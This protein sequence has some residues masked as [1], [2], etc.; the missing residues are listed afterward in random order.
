MPRPPRGSSAPAANLVH[1]APSGRPSRP[2]CPYGPSGTSGSR[3]GRFRCTGPGTPPAAPD[4]R[5]HARHAALRQ[6][7]TCAAPASGTPISQNQRTAG[8][9]SRSWSTVWLAPV[10]RSS[11]G[12]SAVSTTSGT[13]DSSASITAA[14]KCAAAVPDVHTTAT[15]RPLALASPSAQ[16]AA[17]RSSMRTLSRRSPASAR[18][19]N[20]IASGALRDPGATT[21]SR[22][23]HRTSS[24]A[25][26]AASAV[27]GFTGSPEE[28]RGGQRPLAPRLRVTFPG[29]EPLNINLDPPHRQH[30][31]R[32]DER[33]GGHVAGEQAH[34]REAAVV[35]ERGQRGGERDARGQADRR[36]D[37]A[38]HHHGQPARGRDPQGRPYPAERRHLQ[39]DDVRGARRAHGQRVGCLAY[40]LVGR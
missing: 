22:I 2:T 16:N 11:G 32:R 27:A 31:A 18:R 10:P 17:L 40:R 19:W 36:L 37:R 33:V 6:Y 35:V 15:G 38:R 20:S 3:S 1:G 26:A 12:R 34:R 7:A 28:L 25:S 29:S 24:S 23:P 4:A 8:P 5:P 14:W 30:P 39:H 9:Y 21:T 13:A